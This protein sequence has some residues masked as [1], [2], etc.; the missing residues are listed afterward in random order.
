MFTL[1]KIKLQKRK[2]LNLWLSFWEACSKSKEDDVL[3]CEYRRYLK[4]INNGGAFYWA[5]ENCF[6]D[7]RLSGEFMGAKWR[8]L[9][10]D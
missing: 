8:I 7:V 3:E 9:K 4:I 10:E 1:L 2:V 5:D 6:K